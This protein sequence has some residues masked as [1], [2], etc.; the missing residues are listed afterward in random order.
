[1][2]TAPEAHRHL[3]KLTEL[4]DIDAYLHM[5]EVIAKREVW[6][7]KDWAKIITPFLTGESQQAYFALKAPKNDDYEALKSEIL[8]RV[9]LSPVS[10]AQQ[11]NTWSFDDGSPV[12]SQSYSSCREG[13]HREIAA[14]TSTAP[15]GAI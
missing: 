3:T 9:G 4:D 5:F 12:Q 15:P 1:M 2:N 10:A 13:G 6:L 8:A 7:K 11:F 14:R